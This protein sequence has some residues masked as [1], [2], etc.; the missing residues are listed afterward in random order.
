MQ[1][2]KNRFRETFPN[3]SKEMNLSG[4]KVTIKSVRSNPKTAEKKAK[5]QEDFS[6]YDPDIIDFLRRCDTKQQAEE[7][8]IFME[9]RGEITHG[10][11]QKLRQQLNQKGLRSFGSKKE[12]GYYF[13]AAKQSSLT[14]EK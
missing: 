13:K 5:A 2:D 3:L 4:Q 9:N 11:A 1:L 7:I 14:D 10:Y 8:I 12:E 6:N